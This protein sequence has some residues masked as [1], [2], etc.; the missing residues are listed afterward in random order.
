MHAHFRA[1]SL[2]LS[3][4]LHHT[5]HR[6]VW[7]KWS[8][9][10]KELRDGSDCL[11]R[12]TMR[13]FDTLYRIDRAI[14]IFVT[15]AAINLYMCIFK[16]PWWNKWE[17]ASHCFHHWINQYAF[18]ELMFFFCNSRFQNM[19]IALKNN[20]KYSTLNIDSLFHFAH[21]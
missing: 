9:K 21:R 2:L 6:L 16:W 15:V 14:A 4:F 3:L 20:D 5:M 7:T 19:R 8:K 10:T 18:H 12:G 13:W 1:L 17:C 11:F